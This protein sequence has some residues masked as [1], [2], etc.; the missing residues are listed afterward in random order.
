MAKP[1]LRVQRIPIFVPTATCLVQPHLTSS[2]H[3]PSVA[4]EDTLYDCEY[5]SR[6]SLPITIATSIITPVSGR[7]DRRGRFHLN[8]TSHFPRR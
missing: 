3:L 5:S 7:T 2:S 1:R 4:D 8:P 6:Q